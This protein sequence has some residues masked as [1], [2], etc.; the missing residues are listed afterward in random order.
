MTV[1]RKL[2]HQWKLQALLAAKTFPF[3]TS[4]ALNVSCYKQEL[5]RPGLL[6]STLLLKQSNKKQVYVLFSQLLARAWSL[7]HELHLVGFPKKSEHLS[8]PPRGQIHVPQDGNSSHYLL[9]GIDFGPRGQ[10][11]RYKQCQGELRVPTIQHQPFATELVLL[12]KPKLLQ[13]P[14]ESTQHRL[15]H[16]WGSC[17]VTAPCTEGQNLHGQKTCL[18]M[19]WLLSGISDG[20]GWLFSDGKVSQLWHMASRDC[21]PSPSAPAPAQSFINGSQHSSGRTKFPSLHS[22]ML[23][24]F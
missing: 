20:T 18:Q 13:S 8:S 14:E 15:R 1:T 6:N 10:T 5:R 7:K 12:W 17:L 22:R 23:S 24:Q 16:L 21:S 3:S 19:F 4:L 2:K 11:Q 9:Q